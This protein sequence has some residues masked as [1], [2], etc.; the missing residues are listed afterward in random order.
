M[1]DGA[2]IK[3]T[4]KRCKQRKRHSRTF[5]GIP[6]IWDSFNYYHV[7]LTEDEGR[8]V[9]DGKR[10][11][12]NGDLRM[13]NSGLRIEDGGIRIEDCDQMSSKRDLRFKDG[14]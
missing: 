4:W 12:D 11:L 7:L 13:K 1:A 6:A 5:F 3:Q 8:R 2:W 10:R 14:E 9:K